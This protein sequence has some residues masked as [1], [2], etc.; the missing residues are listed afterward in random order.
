MANKPKVRQLAE[1]ERGEMLASFLKALVEPADLFTTPVSHLTATAPTTYPSFGPNYS[2][3]PQVSA[4]F[5]DL[6][7]PPTADSQA[8]G[9]IPAGIIH[10]AGQTPGE[11]L[12]DAPFEL[13]ERVTGYK[14]EAQ[15]R[16]DW[17]VTGASIVFGCPIPRLRF[18]LVWLRLIPPGMLPVPVPG[19]LNDRLDGRVLRRPAEQL[20]GEAVLPP[21]R[22]PAAFGSRTDIQADF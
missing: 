6:I 10:H 19:G 17:E 12:S 3:V 2:P 22:L 5:G 1:R 20:L 18:G 7:V 11:K 16:G 13:K 14:P 8:S 9:D 21:S 4:P 15:A